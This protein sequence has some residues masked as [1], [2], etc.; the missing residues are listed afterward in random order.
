M[1]A[2]TGAP[3][4]T[5]KRTEGNGARLGLSMMEPAPGM[6]SLHGSTAKQEPKTSAPLEGTIRE[7]VPTHGPDE[8][9]GD[10]WRIP[11]TKSAAQLPGEQARSPIRSQ[12][13][14]PARERTSMRQLS[15]DADFLT[16]L[17]I[18]EERDA[19]TA[20]SLVALL[21]QVA[22]L[23]EQVK[24]ARACNDC[25][26]LLAAE[27]QILKLETAGPGATRRRLEC[28]S[29]AW[30]PSWPSLPARLP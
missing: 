4:Y 5:S 3:G 18:A 30:R 29:I 23:K 2:P 9:F 24:A 11:L 14:P 17:Q 15:P 12:P 6:R 1:V 13:K 10:T 7:A 20:A 21:E 26:A 19:S 16:R 22:T 28:S 8:A 25:A 27:A